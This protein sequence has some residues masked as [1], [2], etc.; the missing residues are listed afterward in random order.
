LSSVR[1]PFKGAFGVSNDSPTLI[2]TPITFSV[3]L[4]ERVATPLF[5][6][7]YFKDDN[8][9]VDTYVDAHD[10]TSKQFVYDGKLDPNRV[11][12]MNVTVEMWLVFMPLWIVGGPVL[13]KFTLTS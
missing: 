9:I 4:N 10:S 7:I 5:Y 6:R 2:G 1:L 8:N 3:A 11:Y 12:S 13:S